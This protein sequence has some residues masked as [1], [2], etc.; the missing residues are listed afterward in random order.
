MEKLWVAEAKRRVREIQENSV[1]GI[2]AEDVLN[3]LGSQRDQ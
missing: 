2:P 3:G 1:R